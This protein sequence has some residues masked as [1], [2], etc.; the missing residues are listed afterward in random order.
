MERSI[1]P[2]Y[3]DD[4]RTIGIE[5]DGSS[6][7]ALILTQEEAD[8]LWLDLGMLVSIEA[9]EIWRTDDPDI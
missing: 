9:Q 7:A 4:D 3:Y 5:V 1:K 6:P 2:V 8:Q